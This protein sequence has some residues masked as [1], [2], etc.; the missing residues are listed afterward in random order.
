MP[1]HSNERKKS[2][3]IRVKE[4]D[5]GKRLDAFVAGAFPDLS[6]GAVSRVIRAGDIT[7]SGVPKKPGFRISHGDI[8]AGRIDIDPAAA[9]EVAP[10]PVEIDI[11]FEDHLFLVINKAPG[12]VVHPA[13]GH[14]H[15]TITHGLLHLRPRI[16]GVGGAP[17]RS[18]IVHRLD[19][20]T[21]GIMIVAKNESA[22]HYLVSQFKTRSVAKKYVGIVHGVPETDS[23][24]IVLKIGRHLRQRKKM[25]VTDRE[26]ARDAETH[27]KTRETYQGISLLEFDIKTGRTHQIRVHC[28]AIGHPIVG[29]KTYGLKKPCRHFKGAA[30]KEIIS[31]V[32]RQLL[33]AW[34]LELNHPESGEKMRFE[35]PI[36]A[37]MTDFISAFAKIDQ[38]I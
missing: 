10:E 13:P 21:S 29:D 5:T 11:V 15:G 37:D 30:L 4:D 16:Y 31:T 25:A 3:A 34:Q 24:R 9:D 38:F 23:G 28:A 26:N 14:D 2:F 32:P 18:G 7:V 1:P 22:Y 12:T 20:D 35:A 6:R 19:K 36:P 8:I 33:H 17:A 27:W